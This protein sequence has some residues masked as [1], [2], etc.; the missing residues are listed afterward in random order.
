MQRLLAYGA[1]Q[2]MDGELITETL[3]QAGGD[4]AAALEYLQDFFGTTS[5]S[6]AATRMQEPAAAQAAT[7]AQGQE[8]KQRPAS[9]SSLP[10]RSDHSVARQWE[11]E[12]EIA[13]AQVQV[14]E[15]QTK[16]ESNT[17]ALA[18]LADQ[19]TTRPSWRQGRA[20]RQW[21]NMGELFVKLPEASLEAMVQKDQ[22]TIGVEVASLRRTT[23]AQQTELLRLRRGGAAAATSR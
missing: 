15:L 22:A 14:R 4:A 1:S 2:G 10:R 21:V 11:L 5:M 8:Q 13:T 16:R 9:E 18:A 17:A 3:G 20:N 12:E 23:N 6:S 19:R 7:L